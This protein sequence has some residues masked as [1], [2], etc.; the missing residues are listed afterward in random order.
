MSFFGFDT[1][2]PRDRGQ[3]PVKAPGFTQATDHFAALPTDDDDDDG[4]VSKIGRN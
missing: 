1:G 4:L 3:H 2:L